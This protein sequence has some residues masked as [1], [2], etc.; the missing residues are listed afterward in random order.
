MERGLA[1]CGCPVPSPELRDMRTLEGAGCRIRSACHILSLVSPSQEN[2]CGSDFFFFLILGWDF[3][4]LA[5]C[6]GTGTST[7]A[8]PERGQH[9]QN[10]TSRTA[11]APSTML[12][13]AVKCPSRGGF[14]AGTPWENGM[15]KW[16]VFWGESTRC[17]YIGHA[18]NKAEG[19]RHSPRGECVA[20]GG[21]G[22][23]SLLC[24]PG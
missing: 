2:L 3:R 24:V 16:G 22:Y 10:S 9:Q 7:G 23:P 6:W 13:P 18:G 5:W 14:A 19:K 17:L 15:S 21:C 11:P 12:Y 1:P 8:V 20:H 4:P